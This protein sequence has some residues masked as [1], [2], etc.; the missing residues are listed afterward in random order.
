MA[1]KPKPE[2]APANMAVFGRYILTPEIFE[3]LR[4][5]PSERNGEVKIADTL[6]ALAQDRQVLAVKYKGRRFDCGGAVEGFVEATNYYFEHE[7]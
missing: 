6:K 3:Y 5:T 1:E 7:W 2:D 4:N